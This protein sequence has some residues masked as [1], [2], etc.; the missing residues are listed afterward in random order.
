[1]KTVNSMYDNGLLWGGQMDEDVKEDKNEQ[2]KHKKGRIK[3]RRHKE[4]PKSNGKKS[5]Q[6]IV[7]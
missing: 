3:A 5:S 6:T 2:Q 1:M 4:T 7:K